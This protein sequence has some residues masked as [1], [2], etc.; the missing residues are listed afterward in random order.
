M[1]HGGAGRRRS[2]D[3]RPAEEPVFLAEAGH[4]NSTCSCSSVVPEHAVPI[5]M[6]PEVLLS[7]GSLIVIHYPAVGPVGSRHLESA[8]RPGPMRCSGVHMPGERWPRPAVRAVV[9]AFAFSAG[10]LS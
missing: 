5:L 2:Q 7:K 4:V 10:V 9:H 1:C 6:G 3:G 8:F